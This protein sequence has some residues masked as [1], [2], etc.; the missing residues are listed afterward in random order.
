MTQPNHSDRF[1]NLELDLDGRPGIAPEI[2]DAARETTPAAPAAPGRLP[3]RAPRR[4]GRDEFVAGGIAGDDAAILVGWY[5]AG[6][7]VV[8][9]ITAILDR[10]GLPAS[11][12][13]NPPKA[14][15]CAGKAVNKVGGA[16]GLAHDALGS[17]KWAISIKNKSARVGD[18]V[19]GVV[20]T[21]ELDKRTGVLSFE[22]R[23]DISDAVRA[24]YD[25]LRGGQVL[26]AAEVTSWLSSVLRNELGAVA[27]GASNYY[28]PAAHKATAMALLDAMQAEQW[29]TCWT[30]YT[31]IATVDSVRVGLAN[32]LVD[33]IVAIRSE[34]DNRDNVGKRAAANA[35]ARLGQI[36]DRAQAYAA[37]MGAENMDSV[38]NSARELIAFAQ[39][40]TDTTSLR[41][42][43][44]WDE[45]NRFDDQPTHTPTPTPSGRANG[46][47]EA[48]REPE[49]APVVV[50]EPTPVVAPAPRTSDAPASWRKVNGDWA[51]ATLPGLQ[52]HI[53]TVT[54]KNGTGKRVELAQ[55]LGTDE[56]SGSALYAI[57]P[58]RKG[59]GARA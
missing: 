29:G 55:C 30:P 45:I 46:G 13:P 19:R 9:T 14:R 28:V 48:V 52:G 16:S 15:G 11:W 44:I 47:L 40:H 49:L 23:D 21:V 8:S 3:E 37:V 53:V 12:G 1:A 58:K 31:P 25:R 33:E 20:C 51:V 10:L 6:E 7:M 50:P 39:E 56:H 41:G 27:W 24:E 43:L 59:A 22:G 32:A 42:A 17:Y 5:G 36:A 4:Y 34:L 38:V 57:A 26:K 2:L 18:K 35:V 54:R